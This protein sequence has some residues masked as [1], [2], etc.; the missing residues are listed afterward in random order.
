MRKGLARSRSASG[1]F[2][3]KISAVPFREWNGWLYSLLSLLKQTNLNRFML[4]LNMRV[5]VRI[6]MTICGCIIFLS[7]LSLTN[8][9]FYVQNL[10]QNEK[11]CLYIHQIP[12]HS[13]KKFL[14]S[15]STW[16][17]GVIFFCNQVH[18]CTSHNRRSIFRKNIWKM[19]TY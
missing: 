1:R 19:R 15:M 7:L 3:W 2:K 16:L 6:W 9:R 10:L 17:I 14:F 11:F 4:L 13:F 8:L 18:F 5:I 12:D